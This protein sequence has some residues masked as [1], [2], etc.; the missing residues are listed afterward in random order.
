MKRITAPKFRI[1]RYKL[2]EYELR[3]LMLDVAKGNKPEFIGKKV[4][5]PGYYAHITED[6]TLN[7]R[8]PGLHIATEFAIAHMTIKNLNKNF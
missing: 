3:N 1:G 5:E 8:L 2:N 7:G 4:S 6:G